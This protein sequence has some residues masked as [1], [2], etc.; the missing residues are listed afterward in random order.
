VDEGGGRKEEKSGRSVLPPAAPRLLDALRERL[1]YMHYSIRTEEA[2]VYW[3][4]GFVRWA[5]GRRHQREMGPTEVQAFLSMLA[6][7]RRVAAITHDRA[8]PGIET[9]EP[10]PPCCRVTPSSTARA[11]SAS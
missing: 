6:N 4:R 7:E 8:A 5:G 9:R 3:V 2:Y 1:R 11:T 10:L